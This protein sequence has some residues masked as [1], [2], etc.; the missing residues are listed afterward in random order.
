MLWLYNE[1]NQGMKQ[2][3]WSKIIIVLGE[4]EEEEEE[5]TLQDIP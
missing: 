2:L 5:D 3:K 1:I 4:E